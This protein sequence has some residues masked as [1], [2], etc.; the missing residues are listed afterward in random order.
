M[1]VMIKSAPDTPDGLRG[2]TL[3]RESGADLVLLQNGVHFAEK[4]RLMSFS[5]QVYLLDEDKRLR[6]LRDSELDSR[7]KTIDFEKL[8]DIITGGENVVGMF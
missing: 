6:G 1:I 3:A 8:T 4:E 5:G 2:V 7:A